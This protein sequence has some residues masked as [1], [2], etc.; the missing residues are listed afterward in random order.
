MFPCNFF[1]Y[2]SQ[3]MPKYC[4]GHNQKNSFWHNQSF[5]KNCFELLVY[6]TCSRAEEF[7]PKYGKRLIKRRGLD[8]LHDFSCERS[9]TNIPVE[10]TSCCIV[11]TQKG[12]GCPLGEAVVQSI[13]HSQMAKTSW[14]C[15]KNNCKRWVSEGI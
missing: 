10:L 6:K 8:K 14:G 7:S 15:G 9:D 3:L 4:M 2:F 5:I 11:S 13:S 12:M 1:F